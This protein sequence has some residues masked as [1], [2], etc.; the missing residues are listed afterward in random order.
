MR[1]AGRGEP[2]DLHTR[3]A[4]ERRL[5]GNFGGVRVYRGPLAEEVT[6]RY[7]ADAVTVG[8][9]EMILVREGWQ[10]NFSTVQGGALLAHELTHVRQQQRGLH[11]HGAG[12]TSSPLER[13]AHS[14]QDS[15]AR[16]FGHQADNASHEEYAKDLK[17]HMTEVMKEALKLYEKEK[18][19]QD[20][21]SNPNSQSEY[22]S[23]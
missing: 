14:E 10:S 17:A 20:V 23:D 15:Y 5:G 4:M 8:G 19:Q 3:S 18:Q 22:G 9:T 7:R 11:F 12:D 16:D 2:L 13:E 1:D 6:A 21:R